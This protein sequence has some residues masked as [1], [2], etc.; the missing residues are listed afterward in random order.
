[1]QRLNYE[2]ACLSDRDAPLGK[3][4]VLGPHGEAICLNP[5]LAKEK[6]SKKLNRASLSVEEADALAALESLDRKTKPE[7]KSGGGSNRGCGRGRGRGRGRRA[8]DFEPKLDA[9]E[10]E[11]HD[12][13]GEPETHDVFDDD[14]EDDEDED[15]ANKHLFPLLAKV[16]EEKQSVAAPPAGEPSSSS[17]SKDPMPTLPSDPKVLFLDKGNWVPH[18]TTPTTCTATATACTLIII[19][20]TS[21][22][23]STSTSY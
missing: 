11:I 23:S 13:E 4:K 10:P 15:M 7:P 2:G 12:D 8:A 16:A 14:I 19:T 22:L 5:P 9:F 1:M 20:S 18:S 3:L 6:I 21:H 17:S